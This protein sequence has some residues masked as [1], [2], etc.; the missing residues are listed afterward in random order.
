[1]GHSCIRAHPMARDLYTVPPLSSGFMWW[2]FAALSRRDAACHLEL[3][4]MRSRE[5]ATGVGLS[6]IKAR[7]AARHV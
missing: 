5:T 1:M 6:K 2:W 4:F 3:R 7:R